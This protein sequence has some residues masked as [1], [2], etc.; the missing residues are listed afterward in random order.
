MDDT[1]IDLSLLQVAS[2]YGLLCVPLFLAWFFRLGLLKSM[3]V[4]VLRMSVQLFLVGLYLKVLFDV[5]SAALSLLWMVAMLAVADFSIVSNAGLSL[6]RFLPLVFV[7]VSVTSLGVTLFFVSLVIRPEPFYDARYMIPIFGMILGNCMRGNVLAMERFYRGIR[8]REKEFVTRQM[9]GAS[10]GEAAAPYM[11]L[12][13]SAAVG[14][15]VATMATMGIV[16]L[17]GMMT[18]QVLGGSMP[19]AAIK[20]QVAIMISIFTVMVSGALL[21]ILLSRRMAFDRYGMLRQDIFARQ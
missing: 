3:A 8:D 19:M 13:L 1:T 16:S 21:N 17:P 10:L 15:Q 11:K 9:L 7:G 18:G 5:N 2:I 12:A 6:R 20:Y 4:A 14:P